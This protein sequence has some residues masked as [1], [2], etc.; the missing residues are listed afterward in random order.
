MSH[1][2]SVSAW[3]KNLSPAGKVVFFVIKLL[4]IYLTWYYV[5]EYM[6]ASDGEPLIVRIWWFGYHILLKSTMFLSLHLSSLFTDTN[7][8]TTYRYFLIENHGY[9]YVGNPCLCADVMCLFAAFIIAYPGRWK[10][11]LW[12]IPLG[13]LAIHLINVLRI[14]ALCLTKIYRPEWM[15]INHKFIFNIIVFTFVF[16]L[17]MIWVKRFS[18]ADL[19]K[20]NATKQGD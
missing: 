12:F 20:K 3:L 17:W 4:A 6:R 11:K 16:I 9:L 18:G 15:D 2:F 5:D 14:A 8:T 1:R 7:I 13:L 10:T 19:L